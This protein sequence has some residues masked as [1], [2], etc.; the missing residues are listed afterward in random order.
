MIDGMLNDGRNVIDTG[1]FVKGV[2]VISYR[3]HDI[4]KNVS[5]AKLKIF[6][7]SKLKMNLSLYKLL[8][9]LLCAV[10]EMYTYF[11]F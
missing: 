7:L 2:N 11:N 9:L 8:N 4:H 10:I 5:S 6:I 3:G 1:Y